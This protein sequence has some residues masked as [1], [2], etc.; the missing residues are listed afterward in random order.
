LT[1]TGKRYA[2]CAKKSEQ[3]TGFP[4]IDF[5]GYPLPQTYLELIG[6]FGVATVVGG[7]H[8]SI[9]EWRK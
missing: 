5:N 2:A 7:A 9:I 1:K 4:E 3:G 8:D 6:I